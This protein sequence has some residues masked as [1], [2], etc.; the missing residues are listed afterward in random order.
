MH[1]WFQ[2]SFNSILVGIGLMTTYT[3]VLLQFKID[4]LK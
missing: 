3:I 2:L 1:C 4:E